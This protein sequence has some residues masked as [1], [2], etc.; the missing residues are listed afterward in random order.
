MGPG[1]DGRPRPGPHP[2]PGAEGGGRGHR[3]GAAGVGPVGDRADGRRAGQAAGR[4]GRRPAGGPPGVR[5]G[6]PRVHRR[7]GGGGG[8]GG[9]GARL[10]VALPGRHPARPHPGRRRPQRPG[11]RHHLHQRPRGA[12][13]VR[14]RG[15]AAGRRR[16]P[17]GLQQRPRRRLRRARCAPRRP[18]DQG[19]DVPVEP[20]VGRLGLLVRALSD[21]LATRRRTFTVGGKELVV[22][23][24]AIHADGDAAVPL[25]SGTGRASRPW[26]PARAWSS[27]GP[28]SWS[29]SGARPT[30]TPTC[31]KW[32]WAGSGGAWAGARR[33]SRSPAPAATAWW[34]TPARPLGERRPIAASSAPSR[35]VS[36]GCG[37]PRRPGRWPPSSRPARGRRPWASSPS[38]S[39]ALEASPVRMSTSAGRMKRGSLSTSGSQSSMP[40]AAKAA[41]SRSRMVWV[42][43]VAIT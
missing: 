7:P 8:D 41:S 26:P 37:R 43:P 24:S 15:R 42:S 30:S 23:G 31:S 13:P 28:P 19:I 29:G 39:R 22:Q 10:P 35:L 25:G 14:D 34:S 3:R 36:G 18:S 40:A 27:T 16:P 21:D 17:A 4:R 38:W 2:G 12:Q 33:P 9:A 5:D 1:P 6:E 11:R 20:K 32:W